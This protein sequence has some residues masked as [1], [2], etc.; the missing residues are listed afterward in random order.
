MM[1][2]NRRDGVTQLELVKLTHLK[3]PTISIT[4]Q[5]LEKYGYVER[6]HDNYDMR[7]V[8]V[9]LTEKGKS[10]NKL[11]IKKVISAEENALK[12]LSD[13]EAKQ[14]MRLLLKIREDI[15]ENTENNKFF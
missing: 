9:Y 7:A 4:L 12:S 2:L 3:A 13:A 10:Y 14:L 1:E 11:I 5:K 8:R 6:K 15:V